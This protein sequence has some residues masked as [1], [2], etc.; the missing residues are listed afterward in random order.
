MVYWSEEIS[1]NWIL[2][3]LHS[4][5]PDPLPPEKTAVDYF[6]LTLPS[7]MVGE[8]SISS[9]LFTSSCSSI[10]IEKCVRELASKE[11]FLTF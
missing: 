7:G 8:I 4:H 3:I 2:C 6:R 10:N 9:D 1:D 5:C 11:S